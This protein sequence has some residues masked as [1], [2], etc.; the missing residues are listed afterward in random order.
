MLVFAAL[1]CISHCCYLSSSH[2]SDSNRRGQ[3]V[4]T[5]GIP[6]QHLSTA[7]WHYPSG[8]F[9]SNLSRPEGSNRAGII[10]AEIR[11]LRIISLRAAWRWWRDLHSFF[12]S[13][14]AFLDSLPE[15]H[16]GSRHKGHRYGNT[17]VQ[18]NSDPKAFVILA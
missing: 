2:S 18:S 9:P 7:P 16:S 10:F 13:V 17:K 12:N 15:H 5:C 6:H 14:H 8:L 4:R 3:S 11:A 1:P